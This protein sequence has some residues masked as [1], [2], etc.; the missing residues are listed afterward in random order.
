MR[1]IF[2]ATLIMWFGLMFSPVIADEAEEKAA[3]GAASA[4]LEQ[5]DAEKYAFSWQDASTYF[6]GAV[7]EKGWTDA[8]NGT[9]K[10]LGKLRSRKLI[11]TQS[12]SSLPGAPDGN[13]VVMRFDTSFSNKKGA[14][15]T[16][17]FMREKGGQWKA[18]GYYIQ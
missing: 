16:V 18:A 7:T 13:Y 8:L 3:S 5:I 17:T 11:K 6:R 15:E 4:W 12:A 14:V 10:P 2:L 1:K 9:R